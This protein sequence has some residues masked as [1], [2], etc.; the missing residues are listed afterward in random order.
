M[1]ISSMYR[2]FFIYVVAV[3]LSAVAAPA[4]Q[5]PENVKWIAHRGGVV[6]ERFA[7][8]SPASLEAAREH[9]YWMIECDIRE[10]ADHRIIVHHDPNFQRF[11]NDPRRV[12][13]LTYAEVRK[14]RATPGGTAPMSFTELTQLAAKAKLRIML[15]VKEPEHAE[16]FYQELERDLRAAGLLESTYVI[17]LDS[18][19]RYFKGK[20]RVGASVAHLQQALA[21]GEDLAKLYFLF[22]WG[23]EL[24][25]EKVRY[26]QQHQVAVVPS[27]NTFHY[28]QGGRGMGSEGKT[29][30]G[31]LDPAKDG[32]ADL[33]RLRALGVSEFQIDSVYEVAFR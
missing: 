2:N 3:S 27:V 12:T 16:A 17:G 22:E 29:Y 18:A 25:A 10:T 6:D 8:N 31:G 9:G 15:D 30:P 23:R 20:A 11:Y 33:Q 1:P 24:T 28:T 32:A 7:E 26:A 19:L 13:E 21:A 5:P 14:L 4:P